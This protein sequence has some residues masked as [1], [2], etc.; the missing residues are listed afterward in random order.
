M[1]MRTKVCKNHK[2]LHF[3]RDSDGKQQSSNQMNGVL[4]LPKKSVRKK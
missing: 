2:M 4:R 1:Y 3:S